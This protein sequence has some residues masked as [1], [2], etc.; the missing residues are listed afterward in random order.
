MTYEKSWRE[1]SLT[2]QWLG[3]CTFTTKAVA[4]VL[5]EL[6]FPKLCCQA[7]EKE[8]ELG[9]TCFC[10]CCCCLLTKSSLAPLQFHGL[11]STSLLCPWHFPTRNTRVGGYFLLQINFSKI[12][13]QIF[14]QVFPMQESI[15]LKGIH[16]NQF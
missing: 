13:C 12:S 14:L 1:N 2:V 8:T 11:Q 16:L 7:K 15:A 9:C 10:C 5:G 4:S 3:P 6:S